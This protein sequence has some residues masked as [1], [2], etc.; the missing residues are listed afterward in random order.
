MD[1]L[2]ELFEELGFTDVATFIAS[3]NVVFSAASGTP[4]ELT[5]LIEQHLARRLGYGVATFLRSP[6][7]LEAIARIETAGAGRLGPVPASHYV[8]FL[9]GPAPDS[10]QSR[11]ADLCSEMDDF[12]FSGAEIH[13]RIQGKLT[14]SP[15]FRTG[16]ERATQG[17]PTTSRNMNTLRRLV[18]K[19]TR[20]EEP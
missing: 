3:G 14:E 5:H 16:I 17:A 1:R 10:M 8:I 15:L 9:H 13:W 20:A 19:T 11:F 4:D 7:E 2:R 18:A 6:D 12:Q